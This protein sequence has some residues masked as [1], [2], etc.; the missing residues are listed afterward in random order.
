[1][2]VLRMAAHCRAAFKRA[3]ALIL[4]LAL[5]AASGAMAAD[6][7][8]PVDDARIDKLT[9]LVVEAVPFGRIFE[10]TA[11]DPQWPLQTETDEAS[12]VR[13]GCLRE[14][15]SPAGYRRNKRV[16]VVAYVK[17]NPDR[18]DQDIALLENG[19]ASIMGMAI[20]AGVDSKRS[21]KNVD[22]RALLA[23]VA[24][25]KLDAFMS[26]VKDDKFVPLR[27]LSGLLRAIEGT[28]AKG[29]AA[30]EEHGE[31]MAARVMQQAVAYCDAQQGGQAG[32]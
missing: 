15:L 29:A 22:A 9:D 8:A 19:A 17:D 4:V 28:D 6:S 26:F 32:T 21:G 12:A 14:Q 27:R 16:E 31:M 1:M 30:N 13:R 24:P 2:N 11:T 23:N 25:E 18:V 10:I 7:S 20:M 5:S 3:R